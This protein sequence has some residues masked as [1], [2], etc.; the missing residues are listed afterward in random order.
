VL[1]RPRYVAT[2]GEKGS[3]LITGTAAPLSCATFHSGD[4]GFEFAR[5]ILHPFPGPVR[6]TDALT[7]IRGLPWRTHD[8]GAR[9]RRP[10]REP[11]TLEKLADCCTARLLSSGTRFTDGQTTYSRL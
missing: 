8:W 9:I 4:D 5:E 6:P 2:N 7:A 1:R 3:R 11:L 10:S